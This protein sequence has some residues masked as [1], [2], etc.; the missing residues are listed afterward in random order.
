MREFQGSLPIAIRASETAPHVS[1]K[2]RLEERVG[3]RRAIDGDERA[4]RR[5]L[6][7]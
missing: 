2:L 7:A 1:E 3:K 4:R 6:L 5:V